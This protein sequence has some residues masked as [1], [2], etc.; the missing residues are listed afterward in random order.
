MPFWMVHKEHGDMP[1]YDTGEKDR[2][3]KLGWKLL[4]TGEWPARGPKQTGYEAWEAANAPQAEAVKV[5]EAPAPAAVPA[6]A[7]PAKSTAKKKK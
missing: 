7:A 3:E 2:I 6:P 4:N 1:V 5:E